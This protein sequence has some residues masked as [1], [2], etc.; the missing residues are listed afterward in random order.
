[1][2]LFRSLLLFTLLTTFL[3]AHQT[4]LSFF[5]LY[6]NNDKTIDVVYKKPLSDTRGED[7]SI[8]YPSHCAQ[9]SPTVK[10]IENGFIIRT[11]K[12]NCGSNGL[13]N[14]RIWVEG[15]V[16]S[17]RG[18]LVRY[19][20]SENIYKSLLRSTTPFMKIDQQSS[21]W[22][23][24]LEYVQLG[25]LHILEGFD[26][27]SFVMG[28]LILSTT[29]KKLLYTISAFTLSHSI[30]LISGVLGIATINT[31]YV[32]AM[33]ALSI[34]F[35]AKEIML[36][37]QTF[38]KKHLGVVAFIF[39]LVHGFGF[40]SSLSSIGLPHDEIPL[41]LFSFNLGIEL[42]Q[43]IFIVAAS[44]VLKAVYK[45]LAEKKFDTAVAYTIGSVSSFWLLERILF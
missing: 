33:I 7:I 29:F 41:S 17:D 35:L 24:F 26:H 45:F 8:N 39:G 1:M 30:T 20:N 44:I 23:L 28:L 2:Y 11:Y 32:E 38:T 37:R 3:K 27:L 16:S 13:Q 5:N 22:K 21:K 10:I 36:E 6:E 15:L 12:L 9:L 4:G 34:L 40:S 19:E 31:S 43:I 14:S 18:V 42:G 25:I